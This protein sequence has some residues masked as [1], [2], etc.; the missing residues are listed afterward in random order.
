MYSS[1][2]VHQ[3]GRVAEQPLGSASIVA[4]SLCG[5]DEAVRVTAPSLCPSVT[6]IGIHRVRRKSNKGGYDHR[7]QRLR[8]ELLLEV[9]AVTDRAD[10]KPTDR[11]LLRSQAVIE[12]S[13]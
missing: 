2:Q 10:A 13:H 7:I 8:Q 1:L 11:R 4:S 5:P 12:N 3:A 9:G 6:H